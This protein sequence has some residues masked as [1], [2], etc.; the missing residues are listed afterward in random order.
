MAPTGQC[1]L[2]LPSS[3][4]RLLVR[5]PRHL[6]LLPETCVIRGWA[7]AGLSLALAFTPTFV[8]ASAPCISDLICQSSEWGSGLQRKCP[9][10]CGLGTPFSCTEP[11]TSYCTSLDHTAVPIKPP[12]RKGKSSE[13]R[14]QKCSQHCKAKQ[15]TGLFLRQK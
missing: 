11:Q 2:G 6:H 1:A 10:H 15:S 12:S 3:L 5:P 13:T 4:L 7:Q 8:C 9:P 14:P